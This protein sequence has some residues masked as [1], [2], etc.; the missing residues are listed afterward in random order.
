MNIFPT[1]ENGENSLNLDD[2]FGKSLD[3]NCLNKT[4]TSN[5][6]IQKYFSKTLKLRN[7]S[8]KTC[9]NRPTSNNVIHHIFHFYFLF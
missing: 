9:W 5:N 2:I 8:T 4:D 7:V 6:D 3:M 1:S